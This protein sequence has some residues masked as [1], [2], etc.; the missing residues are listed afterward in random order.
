MYPLPEVKS[1]FLAYVEKHELV[2]RFEQQFINVSSDAVF[3]AALYGSPNTKGSTTAPEFAK[4]EAALSALCDHMQ[5]WYR[6]AVPGDEP[7]TKKGALRPIAVTCKVRQGR[8][9]KACTLITGF[10]PYQLSGDA[11]A[12]TLRVRCASSTSGMSYSS[13]PRSSHLLMLY[14]QK[15]RRWLVADKR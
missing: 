8:R 15:Y 10:E 13:G 4:R 5:P 1:A 6:I 14:T 7:I 2:N 3:A 11:L 12:D 9:G